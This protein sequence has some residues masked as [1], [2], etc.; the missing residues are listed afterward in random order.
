MKEKGSVN[1]NLT[2]AIR[3]IYFFLDLKINFA[4]IETN[5]LVLIQITSIKE[6]IMENPFKMC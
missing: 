4:I 5:I 2:H 1:R 3:K 6:E